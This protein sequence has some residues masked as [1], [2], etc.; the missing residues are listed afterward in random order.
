MQ[1][2]VLR[3]KLRPPDPIGLVRPR[4]ENQL[5]FDSAGTV[6]LVVAPAGSGK[7]TLLAQIAAHASRE[8]GWY[9]ATPDDDTEAALVANLARAVPGFAAPDCPLTMSAFLAGLEDAGGVEGLLICD[10]LHEIAG[11]PAERALERFVDLRPRGLRLLFGSRRGSSINM[12]R[13]RGSG[14]AAEVDGSALRFR[15]WE[16]EE[17]FERIYREPLR[18]DA[19]ALLTRRIGGWA[20]GLQLFHLATTGRSTAARHQAVLELGASSRLVR[21]YLTRHVLADLPDE[22]RRFLLRTCTVDRLTADL[23]DELLDTT[24]SAQILSELELRQLFVSTDDGVE[25]RYHEVL[26]SHLEQVI[27]EELG[28]AG[29]R[30]WYVRSGEVLLSHGR[31]RSAAKAF[32]KA[33]NWERVSQIVREHSVEIGDV[34]DDHGGIS[35]PNSWRRDPWLALAIARR[36]ARHGQLADAVHAYQLAHDMHDEPTYRRQCRAESDAVVGWLP[37]APAISQPQSAPGH[38]SARVRAALSGP[39]PLVVTGHIGNDAHQ[40]VNGLLALV[41]GELGQVGQSLGRIRS[42]RTVTP[43]LSA[44]SG[45]GLAI[46][47][48]A[49]SAGEDAAGVLGELIVVAESDGFPWIARIA[50][51][52]Q[53]VVLVVS[54]QAVWRLSICTQMKDD[55]DL[56]GDRW[57]SALLTLMIGAAR[58]L[59]GDP[60]AAAIDLN[61]ARKRFLELEAPVL[62]LWC[63]I[64]DLYAGGGTVAVAAELA[65]RADE[66]HLRGARALALGAIESRA[67]EADSV[68]RSC[69]FPLAAFRAIQTPAHVD[70]IQSGGVFCFGGLRIETAGASLDAGALRPQARSLLGILALNAGRPCRHEFLED[71]IWPDVGHKV[72][73]HRLQVAVSSIRALLAGTNYAVERAGDAYR[74]QLPDHCSSD[75]R[76]FEDNVNRAHRSVE[77]G[78]RIRFRARALDVYRGELLPSEGRVEFIAAERER[79]RTVAA[80]TALDQAAE[81]WRAGQLAQARQAAELSLR[82]EPYQDRPWELLARIHSAL[83]DDTAAERARRDRARVRAAMGVN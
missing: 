7:T 83:G 24:G 11:T 58:L 39:V 22:H 51:A 10:D 71:A 64:L 65:A 28:H 81:L 80:G 67:E 40:T 37:H 70:A 18:P 6:G 12:P 5:S 54:Q 30:A 55:S 20:A 52:L 25:Y 21:S 60:A 31:M 48:V 33:E 17:L 35:P 42:G 72:A 45:V 78:D 53:E 14:V 82:L 75:V 46:A 23:S 4:L 49:N 63:Q 3:E 62:A 76:T 19:A 68:A 38:W 73:S 29:S 9:R 43:L 41:A 26:R 69:G 2:L 36:H 57:G 47:D 34:V 61:E 79:L 44:L 74:L 32:A 59:N 56:R 13:L 15:P 77:P 27:V 50:H 1:P 8:L 16:V 66:F